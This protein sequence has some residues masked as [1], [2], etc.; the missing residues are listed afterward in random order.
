[1]ADVVLDGVTKVYPNGVPALTAVSLRVA[2]GEL[3]V[4]VGPSAGGKT[5]LLRLIAGLED[6]TTGT[7]RIGGRVVNAV[8]P[9]LRDVA[10]VFQR[11][12]LYPHLNVRQN[13]E[14]GLRLAGGCAESE[15]RRRGDELASL[16]GL[17]DVL[18]RRPSELSGGQ[19]QRVAVGR[20]LVRRPQV[21]L[22]DEPFASLDGPL[23]GELRRELHLLQRRFATTMIHVTHDQAEAMTLADRLVVLH[24]GRLL[25]ADVPERV[26]QRPN[27]RRVAALLGATPM[28]FLEGRLRSDEAGRKLVGPGGELVLPSGLAAPAV[29]AGQ[30]VVLGIRPEDVQ[31]GGSASVRL[32]LTVA[33]VEPLGYGTLVT[34]RRA[35]WQLAVLSGPRTRTPQPGEEVEVCFAPG[36]AHW[37]D[38]QDGRAMT[39]DLAP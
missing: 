20:A 10:L 19:Q 15:V 7:I 5:T 29:A 38:A 37:F 22:L 36:Q 1:M 16:L 14:F 13:L 12:A 21:I 27:D 8:P 3:A 23:R 18:H 24:E 25:Q 11:P 26:Y 30:T 32:N 33:L 6:P 39:V 35:G 28:N 31:M 4:L 17:A 34:C 2:D 9:A